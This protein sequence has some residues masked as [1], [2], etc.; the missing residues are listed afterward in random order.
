M[1]KDKKNSRGTDSTG[2]YCPKCGGE[3]RKIGRVTIARITGITEYDTY[4]D[5][6]K[7]TVNIEDRSVFEQE[8]RILI[9][10]A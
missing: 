2:I 9:T 8:D 5:K 1:V 4:C 10:F 6:C 7:Q 3:L